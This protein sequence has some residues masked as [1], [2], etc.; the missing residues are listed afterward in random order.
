MTNRPEAAAAAGQVIG[1]GSRPSAVDAV[2]AAAKEEN[3]KHNTKGQR[4]SLSCLFSSS[5][6]RLSSKLLDSNNDNNDNGNTNNSNDK[7]KKK[8]RKSKKLSMVETDDDDDDYELALQRQRRQ[9]VDE[10]EQQTKSVNNI[11]F[12]EKL[13]GGSN[14]PIL[15]SQ[16]NPSEFFIADDYLSPYDYCTYEERRKKQQV[17][18]T[19]EQ[20][21]Q[22][23]LLLEEEE[24]QKRRIRQLRLSSKPRV[25]AFRRLFSSSS[26]SSTATATA[27]RQ[28]NVE[29]N[30]SDFGL[31]NSL[32]TDELNEHD[33]NN[34]NDGEVVTT[35][36]ANTISP[37]SST[38]S[39][40]NENNNNNSNANANTNDNTNDNVYMTTPLHEA[41]RLGFGDFVRVLLANNNAGGADVNEKNGY[42]RTAIHM[43]AGGVTIE[44]ERLINAQQ[45]IAQTQMTTI[46]IRSTVIPKDLLELLRQDPATA[47][48]TTTKKSNNNRSTISSSSK[49]SMA[50]RRSLIGRVLFNR[51]R[52]KNDATTED[53]EGSNHRTASSSS[54]D[55]KIKI[56]PDPKRLNE[57]VTSRMDAMM[58]LLSWIQKDSFQGPSINA[59]DNN[60]RTALHYAAELGRTD[61]CMAILSNFGVILTVVDESSRTPCEVAALQGHS[62]LAA[63]LEARALLYVD[64][65][66]LDDMMD[67]MMAVSPLSS[68]GNS[69]GNNNSKKLVPPFRWFQTMSM[70]EVSQ[71]R[72]TWLLEIRRKLIHISND[73]DD[74]NNISME[75]KKPSSVPNLKN[76]PSYTTWSDNLNLQPYIGASF[77]SNTNAT[78]HEHRHSETELCRHDIIPPAAA[79]LERYLAYHNWERSAAI[80][81]FR[82]DPKGA[83]ATAGVKFIKRGNGNNNIVKANDADEEESRLCTICYDDDVDKENWMQFHSSCNH[84]FCKDCLLDYVKQCAV[85]RTPMHSITCPSH[86]CDQGL[87]FLD[88]QSLLLEKDHTDTFERIKE[89]STESFITSSSNYKYCPHPGC[90]GVVHRLDQPEWTNAGFDKTF[91]DYTGA[92]CTIITD[93][94]KIGD[95]CTLTYEGVE[96]LDYNNCRST[97]QPPKAHRFCFSCLEPVHWPLKCERMKEWKERITEE[98]GEIDTPNGDFNELAQNMWLKANTRPCPHCKAPIEKNDGCNHVVCKSCSFEFCWVCMKAWYLHTIETTD[99]KYNK[100]KQTFPFAV[101]VLH[102][103]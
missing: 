78:D 64:P 53:T 51:N 2:A 10:L 12:I 103:F 48:T 24:R 85:N 101:I 8:D 26:R 58:A 1:L 93:R 22:Q 67:N 66:G 74:N 54:R 59:V 20:Q 75:D 60:G 94:A 81:A 36:A 33:N 15:Q 17:L 83:L 68:S 52:K 18:P 32:V 99:G 27:H 86:D 39:N 62:T 87:S 44:E 55:I 21:H 14:V 92:V 73:S 11:K 91:L 79:D 34:N 63:Q 69:G 61:I 82:K 42:I 16:M 80:D 29:D 45:I 13:L 50:K 77:K 98:I 47:T 41:A 40:N 35:T 72:M 84:G 6:R 7:K 76:G 30:D 97:R 70:N 49:G 46:G 88:V 9:Q 5:S 96:D 95:D 57:L 28:N 38:E 19:A 65:Y 89:A 37:S 56:K 90:E 71:S 3:E 102:C 23:Y 31:V 25:V 43:C 100:Y 4:T